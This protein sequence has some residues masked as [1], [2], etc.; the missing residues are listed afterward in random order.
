MLYHNNGVKIMLI[1]LLVKNFKSYKDEN[2]LLLTSSS[3]IRTLKSHERKVDSLEIMKFAGI[4]GYNASGKT[5]I[6]KA[7]SFIKS[8]V[9]FNQVTDW[10]FSFIEHEDEPTKLEVIFS[11]HELVYQYGFV[12]KKKQNPFLSLEIIDE[13]LNIVGNGK[14]RSKE[15]YSKQNGLN[16]ILFSKV[17]EASFKVYLSGYQKIESTSANRLFLNYI[18]DADKSI[19]DSE[20]YKKLAD[21]FF[22][23]K[24][25]FVVIGANATNL[26]FIDEK[27]LSKIKSY[28]QKFDPSIEDI[29]L[30]EINPDDV[31]KAVPSPVLDDIKAQLLKN[32][33][34]SIT[35]GLNN[36]DFYFFS[37]DANPDI[38]IKCEIL[39]LKHR[40]IKTWFS[41]ADESAGTK[42][43]LVLMSS[44]SN[45]NSDKI[46][47]VDEL[48]RS[49][50]PD[51]ALYICQF[52]AKET[53]N[54][55]TQ[56]IF[57]THN[58]DFM[59]KSLRKDEIYF[60]DKDGDGTSILYPLTD[61]SVKSS[62][63]VWKNYLNGAFS[64]NI[65]PPYG[66]SIFD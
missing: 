14:E 63:P 23:I 29:K 24:N 49:L 17:D 18:N 62:D 65:I 30:K 51:A 1:R 10:N 32:P 61:F 7:T 47:F 2:C 39:I 31:Y 13:Y 19:S 6:L 40:F 60:A 9:G 55:D 36:N 58:I 52:F 16:P 48:E 3:K 45:N 50:H 35:L 46:Y 59:K 12:I 56:F 57:T 28:V 5:N 54:Q 20:L 44:F 34:Q 8:L 43:F 21:V 26:T 11:Y 4:Y 37:H 22:Y 66:R 41:F 25:N 38:L 27:N 53:E 33:H 64:R 15:V 42:K